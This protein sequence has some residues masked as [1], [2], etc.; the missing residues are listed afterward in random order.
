[1]TAC[2]H[3]FPGGAAS[4]SACCTL[5]PWPR[6]AGTRQLGAVVGG[7]V[8]LMPPAQ[9]LLTQV[10]TLLLTRNEDYCSLPVGAACMSR[11]RRAAP[12]TVARLP[13]GSCASLQAQELCST[14]AS[15]AL[16]CPLTPSLAQLLVHPLAQERTALVARVLE[17]ATLPILLLKP[18]GTVA[19]PIVAA[20][21]SGLV[22]WA[23]WRAAA[24]QAGGRARRC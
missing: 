15:Q 10:A 24:L 12:C 3:A 6:A 9:M 2:S 8:L 14:G 21:Q 5:P 18:S 22:A 13:V 16:S 20:A 4:A 17:Y 1:M 7:L 11:R 23:V 19:A